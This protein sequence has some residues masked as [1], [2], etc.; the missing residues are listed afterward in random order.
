MQ[1]QA[2]LPQEAAAVVA[3]DS[4]NKYLLSTYSLKACSDFVSEI[5]IEKNRAGI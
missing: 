3:I 2:V 5:L 1:Y 4:L